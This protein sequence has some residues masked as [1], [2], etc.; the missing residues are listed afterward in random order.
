LDAYLCGLTAEENNSAAYVTH[1]HCGCSGTVFRV[2]VDDDNGCAR[3]TCVRC[4]AKHLMLDSAEFWA[5][6][7]PGSCECPCGADTF[8]VAVAFSRRDDEAL[9]WVTIGLR[10]IAC[11]MMGVYTDWKVDYEPTE[12]LYDAV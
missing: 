12:H 3:R 9:T 5:T 8:E 6:A 10:C 2:E 7:D 1:A 4:G 11:G